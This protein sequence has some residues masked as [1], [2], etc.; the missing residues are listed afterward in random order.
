MAKNSM[1]DV[2]RKKQSSV[3][4]RRSQG[5]NPAV[6]GGLAVLGIILLVAVLFWISRPA[7]PVSAMGEVVQ[8]SATDHVQEGTDSGPYAS[9]P[10]AG[11]KHYAS[12]YRAGFY[13]ESDVAG[14]PQRPEGYLVH[15]L[16]HGY[17]LYY[18][19]CAADPNINC[20]E[21]KQ[22]IQDVQQEFNTRKTIAFPWDTLETPIVMVSWGRLMP[23]ETLD[24][25][26]MRQFYRANLNKAPE[27]N[28]E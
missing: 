12:T 10:P 21:L 17:I 6:W 23:L 28:A 19:N 5:T 16:E 8:I 26:V 7:S 18:Y 27:P 13:N 25:D 24:K 3:R 1:T 14:L 15:N 20:D 11:G 22:A 2:S 4:R 9:D